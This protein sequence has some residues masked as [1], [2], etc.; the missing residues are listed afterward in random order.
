[1]THPSQQCDTS[2]KEPCW[3]GHQ[4]AAAPAAGPAPL[5]G[6]RQRGRPVLLLLGEEGE[7]QEL[8]AQAGGRH[9]PPTLRLSK[10]HPGRT[11]TPTVLEAER[12]SPARRGPALR[13]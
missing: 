5:P 10:T 4:L 2:P 9:G 1:M 13:C 3:A 7:R 6:R 11:A 12:V 8:A